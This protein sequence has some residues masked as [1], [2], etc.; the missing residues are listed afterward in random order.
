MNDLLSIK[1]SNDRI[2]VSARELH[3]ALEVK[4]AFKDWF[5]R[6]CE[7]GFTE[8]DDYCSF[9]SDRVDGLPGKPRN[10]AQLT[11]DMAKEICMIQ[12]TEK[13]K[14]CRQYFIQVERDWNSPD[15]I[16]A[17]ALLM[18]NRQIDGLHEDVAQRDQIIQELQPKAT[19]Y[20]LILQS[21]GSVPISVIAK[22]YG[23]SAQTLNN[24]LHEAGVQY[25]QGKTWLLYQKHAEYGYTQSKTVPIV[26]SDGTPDSRMN[27][28]WTQKGRIFI[29]DLLKKNGILPLIECENTQEGKKYE[30]YKNI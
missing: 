23:M 7:Y 14:D 8:G 30:Q 17:R 5:P 6:M 25:K 19:Y 20:D 4:T 15:K 11:I 22:D 27:T 10:D 28:N 3:E 2:T 12:R 24:K 16:M 1:N 29:Y 26:R 18:A 13:G 9:L 21:K